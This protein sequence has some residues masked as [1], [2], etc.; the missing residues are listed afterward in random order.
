MSK[1]AR[2]VP[3]G[4]W[5]K[6][7]VHTGWGC[8]EAL[9]CWVR[10][11]AEDR[12][13]NSG[14]ARRLVVRPVS[15]LRL[16][17]KVRPF[18]G[19]CF[20]VSCVCV[21]GPGLWPSVPVLCV[22]L[23][24]SCAP[25]LVALSGFVLRACFKK[26]RRPRAPTQRPGFSDLGGRRPEDRSFYRY[27]LLRRMGSIRLVRYDSGIGRGVLGGHFGLFLFFLSSTF[28]LM[29][30][31]SDVAA[32]LVPSVEAAAVFPP[33]HR[34][35]EGHFQVFPNTGSSMGLQLLP[36]MTRERRWFPWRL[37]WALSF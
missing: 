33:T 4:F 16:E 26:R 37:V 22:G 23:F 18:P 20:L 12:D 9:S 24:P 10:M 32:S 31:H 25:G 11:V 36:K 6:R 17:L 19:A 8:G 34:H 28:P 5:L 2:Q 29:S 30:C 35:L 14:H 3:D 13:K 15:L 27:S 7:A 1:G 21:G